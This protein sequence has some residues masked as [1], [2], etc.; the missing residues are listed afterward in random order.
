MAYPTIIV[1][2]NIFI[3]HFRKQNKIN[4]TLSK[5]ACKYKIA[6]TSITVY[7]LLMG[8]ITPDHE[9]DLKNIL[10]GLFV[11]SFDEEAAK[12]AAQQRIKLI[13]KNKQF[14]IRDILIAGV[15][16]KEKLPLA[17]LNSKHFQD[18]INIELINIEEL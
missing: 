12:I 8:A 5:L 11:Y 9:T 1:D 3:E 10:F 17:T 16:L 6:T 7:E 18:F 2:T 14:E 15:V 13:K 4:S